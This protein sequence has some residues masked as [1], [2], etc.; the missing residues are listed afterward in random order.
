MH[1]T[2]LVK[3]KDG[4]K[5]K[6]PKLLLKCTPQELH[7]VMLKPVDKGGFAGTFNDKGNVLIGRQ[8]G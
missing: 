1:D 4:N 2:L 6:M 3:E 7:N 8:K 5:V